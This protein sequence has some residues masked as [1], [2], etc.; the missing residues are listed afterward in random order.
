[1]KRL[2][3]R[4]VA[5]IEAALVMLAV[6]V[7]LVNL[8]YCGRLALHGAALDS[9]AASAARY[10]AKVPLEELHD[11]ARRA[12]ALAAARRMVDDTLA[13]AKVDVQELQVEFTCEL[14]ACASLS[15]L[16][17][18][19]K[20]AVSVVAQFRDEQF[21]AYLPATLVAFVEVGRE[22]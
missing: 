1:M 8:V 17:A 21:G 13:A 12:V 5:A 14:G 10:L 18:P 6:S 15:S 22:N 2:R 11:S 7:L 19:S 16:V 4:G 3:C 9:A 20:V